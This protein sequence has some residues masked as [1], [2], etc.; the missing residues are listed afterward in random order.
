MI[1]HFSETTIHKQRHI[2]GQPRTLEFHS[3]VSPT[4][5]ICV[6]WITQSIDFFS[7]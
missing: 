5:A 7:F 1:I 2:L 4:R 6:N 3:C